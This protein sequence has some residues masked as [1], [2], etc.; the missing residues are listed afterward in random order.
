L[1]EKVHV[2]LVKSFARAQT[3]THTENTF[4]ITERGCFGTLSYS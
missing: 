4:K 2:A 1:K 3:H